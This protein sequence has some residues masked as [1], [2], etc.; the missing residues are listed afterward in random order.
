[1]YVIKRGPDY[2]TG[3]DFSPFQT[4]A[5]RFPIDSPTSTFGAYLLTLF[6]GDVR[7]VELESTGGQ[8]AYPFDTGFNPDEWDLVDYSPGAINHG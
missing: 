8:L 7:F 2:F 5:K 6:D 3:S 1:M 4:D